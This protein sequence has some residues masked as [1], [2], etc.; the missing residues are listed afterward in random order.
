M[1]RRIHFADHMQ[2]LGSHFS[3]DDQPRVRSEMAGLDSSSCHLVISYRKKG[4]ESPP[5]QWPPGSVFMAPA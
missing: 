4:R 2:A 1:G 3:A 5:C